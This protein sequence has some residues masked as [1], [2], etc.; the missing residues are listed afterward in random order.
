MPRGRLPPLALAYHAVGD[1]PLR[2]DPHRLFVRFEDLSRQVAKLRGWGYSFVSFGDLARLAADGRAEGHVALTFDDGYADNSV[3]PELGVPAT[4]FVVSGWLGQ[5]HRV[6]PVAPI[7]TADATRDL[8]A[9]GIEI[10][11]HT[12]THPDL[13]TLGY[14]EARSELAGS[15]RDLEAVIEAPVEVAA[16][17]FGRA[18]HDTV[19][20]ARD[21]GF[22]AA[23]LTTAEG[24]WDRPLELPRQAVENGTT[25]LGLRM[26][27]DGRYEPMMR[28]YPARAAR[29]LIR[30]IR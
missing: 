20:A 11:A 7:L 12:V 2:E 23:C 10:G 18:N 22:R 5:L 30:A 13:T 29:K 19:R 4:V 28:L 16:Y 24:S 3:L 6:A 26:K 8:H 1:V 17:P 21:A 25:L 9:K 27:R 15:K 14:E